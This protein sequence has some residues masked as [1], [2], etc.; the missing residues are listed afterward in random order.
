[1]KAVDFDENQ[2]TESNEGDGTV[3][4]HPEEDGCLG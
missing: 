4:I 2:K 1:M 3:R